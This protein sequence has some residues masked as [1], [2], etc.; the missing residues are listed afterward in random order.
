MTPYE[1][2]R[3]CKHIFE[4]PTEK[5]RP[6]LFVGKP[7]VGKSAF[8]AQAARSYGD[9][10]DVRLP[11][12][13]PEDLRFPI[14]DVEKKTLTWVQSIFPTDPDWKGVICLE[15]IGNCPLSMQNCCYQLTHD[16]RLGD[17]HLPVAARVVACTNSVEDRCGVHRMSMALINRFI[18]V[19]CT[20]NLEDWQH[21]AIS[22]GGVISPIRGFHNATQGRLLHDFDP[23][24]EGPF[25]S[26]RSWVSLSDIWEGTPASLRREAAAGCIGDAAATEFIAW[27]NL[28]DDLPDAKA[29]A[30]G[31]NVAVPKKPDVVYALAAALAEV[32]RKANKKQLNN[33]MS[34]INRLP[35]EYGTMAGRDCASANNS[36]L[37]VD[38]AGLWLKR[39]HQVIINRII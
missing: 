18:R 13:L 24:K 30:E 9:F 8:T 6:I 1:A 15:E 38:A 27:F 25:P 23:A 37:D 36:I 10:L 5:T 29:I 22:E 17:Y 21:W 26:P 19:N 32:C 34:Y 33:V 31:E 39:N 14:V 35:E 12:H 2:I 11:Y 16:R 3:F 7:G 28:T 4:L 20:V